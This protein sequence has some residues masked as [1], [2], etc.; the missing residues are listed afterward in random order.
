MLPQKK[1]ERHV[2]SEVQ[3]VPGHAGL[4]PLHAT[5]APQVGLPAVP[6]RAGAHVPS[7]V[8]P[9]AAVQTWHAAPQ[10]GSQ[11]TPSTTLPLTHALTEVL[12]CPFLRPHAPEPL[13]VWVVAQLVCGSVPET[14]GEQVP[15][16][17]PGACNAA[18]QAWQVGQ[19]AVPQQTPSK[20]ERLPVHSWQF[21]PR[22]SP[23]PVAAARLHV[24]PCVFCGSQAPPLPQ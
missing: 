17:P 22:Q 14:A 11:Q 12:D 20:H 8:E 6:C 15:A 7:A 13:Q 18:E 9:S 21:A 19:L 10:L 4:V 5:P 16:V 24:A 1:P 3:L 23:P 2:A